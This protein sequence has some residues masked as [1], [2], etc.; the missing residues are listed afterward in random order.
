M[1][2]EIQKGRREIKSMQYGAVVTT[3]LV[4]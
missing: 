1:A 3:V 4:D 2:I